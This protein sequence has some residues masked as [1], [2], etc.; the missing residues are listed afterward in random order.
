MTASQTSI[1]NWALTK[2]G[3]DRITNPGDDDEKARAAAEIFD[4]LVAAELRRNVWKFAL[5]SA[6]LGEELPAPA[7]PWTRRFPLPANCLRL[8]AV[9]SDP[10]GPA[11]WGLEGRHIVTNEAAP[12]LVRYIRADLTPASFDALFVEVLALK[13]ALELAPRVRDEAGLIDRLARLYLMALAE[14]RRIGAVELPAMPRQ[15]S[16]PWVAARQLGPWGDGTPGGW[17]S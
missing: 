4:G 14:A 17:T 12:L 13:L 6:S 9:G 8:V 16:E 1:T 2:L 3:A 11:L 15:A 10:L 7:L 5:A